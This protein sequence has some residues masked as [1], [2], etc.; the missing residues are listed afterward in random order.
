MDMEH[1]PPAEH[2]H[3]ASDDT[4]VFRIARQD[5]P[6]AAR[7]WQSFAVPRVSGMNVISALQSI[8]AH[9]VPIGG[10][11][12]APPVVWD[13]NCLEEVCGACT[14]VIN[15]RVRQAC[16]ALVDDIGRTGA[17]EIE[18]EPMTKYPVVR[19]LFV[20]RRRMFRGLKQIK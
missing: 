15:G 2:H 16:T 14:M 4:V 19:D 18:L 17:G 7:Y 12:P 8:A 5:R 11:E 9:P 3:A 1:T 10:H 20:D 6:G 13:C